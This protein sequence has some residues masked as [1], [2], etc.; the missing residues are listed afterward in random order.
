[1]KKSGAI[2]PY[3]LNYETAADVF[4]KET[5]TQE[6]REGDEANLHI[7]VNVGLVCR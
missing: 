3:N 1:M 7:N 2:T 5:T 6:G 4:I